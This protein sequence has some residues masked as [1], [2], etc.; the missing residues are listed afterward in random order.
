MSDF[1]NVLDGGLMIFHHMPLGQINSH[2]I[3][4][5]KE[6]LVHQRESGPMKNLI[7]FSQWT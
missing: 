2:L 5:I 6:Y 1:S 7:F 4:A 3:K